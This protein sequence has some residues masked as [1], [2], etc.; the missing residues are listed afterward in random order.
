M[1]RQ[2]RKIKVD[3]L[4]WYVSFD[5][6]AIA[7]LYDTEK[8]LGVSSE[9]IEAALTMLVQ[10]CASKNKIDVDA[11]QEICLHRQGQDQERAQCCTSRTHTG[12]SQQDY[13]F[14]PVLLD[15]Q[16]RQRMHRCLCNFRMEL[17]AF[18]TLH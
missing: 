18:L 13:L 5:E 10:C 6:R 9:D 7:A 16:A 4:R 15:S 11:L 12:W 1:A 3:G 14:P 17:K 8:I 2:S